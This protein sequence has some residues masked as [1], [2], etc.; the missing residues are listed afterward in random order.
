[1]TVSSQSRIVIVTKFKAES[2]Q[3]KNQSMQKKLLG[4]M[5]WNCTTEKVKKNHF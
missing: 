1:M 3:R 4:I 5:W 2:M